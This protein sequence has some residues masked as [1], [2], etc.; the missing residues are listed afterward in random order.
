V[1]VFDSREN[2]W[3]KGQAEAICEKTPLESKLSVKNCDLYIFWIAYSYQFSY[4]KLT[5]N[6]SLDLSLL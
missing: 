2:I 1:E 4:A 6:E 5:F 3:R